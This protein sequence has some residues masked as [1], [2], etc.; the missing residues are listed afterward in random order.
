MM[1][2]SPLAP[3]RGTLV[4]GFGLLLLALPPCAM[5]AEG[6]TYACKVDVAGGFKWESNRWKLRRLYEDKFQLVMQGETFTSESI[7]AVLKSP[8]VACTVGAGERIACADARGGF[9]LF[10]PRT[11]QGG[12]AQLHGATDIRFSYRD[13]VS[14]ELF[15]CERR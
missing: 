6:A 5:P 13:T 7:A 14:V 1:P 15:S 4:A 2:T 8:P 11:S 10:D 3:A 9:L 12:I